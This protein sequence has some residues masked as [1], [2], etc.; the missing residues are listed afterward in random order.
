MN[1]NALGLIALAAALCASA[2]AETLLTVD[3]SAPTPAPTTGHLKLGTAVAPGGH[4]LAVNNQ[5]LLRDG[6]PWLPVMG[7]FHFSR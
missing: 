5:Y 2:Q 6:K 7:E 1:R 4:T 3:A